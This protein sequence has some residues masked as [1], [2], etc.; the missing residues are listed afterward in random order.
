MLR[1]VQPCAVRLDGIEE[2]NV[3]GAIFTGVRDY[4]NAVARF[5]SHA[6]PPFTDHDADA[7]GFDIPRA[8]RGR[9]CRVAPNYD[10]D[11]AMG[12]LPVILLYNGSVRDILGHVEH[13]AGMMSESGGSRR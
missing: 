4:R 7:R 1:A 12:V 6:I 3:C 11:A 5:I 9:V 2:Q 10:D 13:R 8:D